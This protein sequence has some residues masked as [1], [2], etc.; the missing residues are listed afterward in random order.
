MG[1]RRV[2]KVLCFFIS[3]VLSEDGSN[4]LQYSIKDVISTS[5]DS[6][7]SC[8][9]VCIYVCIKYMYM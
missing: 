8:M 5:R 4:T 9:H 2:L 6:S 7:Y 1:V 3:F